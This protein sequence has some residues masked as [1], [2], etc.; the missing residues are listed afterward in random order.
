MVLNP[1]LALT[2]IHKRETEIDLPIHVRTFADAKTHTGWPV[3]VA[4]NTKGHPT[5]RIQQPATE[6]NTF[7]TAKFQPL[8]LEQVILTARAGQK[9]G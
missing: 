9:V 7:F 6:A 3:A 1:N 5:W 2:M 4:P 8:P